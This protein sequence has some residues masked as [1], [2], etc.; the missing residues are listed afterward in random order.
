LRKARVRP[1]QDVSV[2]LPKDSLIVVIGVSGSGKSLLVTDTICAAGQHNHLIS[3][4]LSMRQCL[5]P[6]SRPSC[7]TISGISCVIAVNPIRQTFTPKSTVGTV[8]EIYDYFRILFAGIGGVDSLAEKSNLPELG[9]QIYKRFF[10]KRI[11]VLAPIHQAAFSTTETLEALKQKGFQRV[12]KGGE[13]CTLE[14][15]AKKPKRQETELSMVVD[16]IPIQE[17]CLERLRDSIETGVHLSKGE[18]DIYDCDTT[19]VTKFTAHLSSGTQP[20][21]MQ[22]SPLLFSFN[23][24]Q[25]ACPHCEGLGECRFFS[26]TLVVPNPEKSL[27]EGAIKPWER[28][29]KEGIRRLFSPLMDRYNI[30]LTTAFNN[31]PSRLQNIIL[32][33]E[34]KRFAGVIPLLEQRWDKT[35]N[36]WVKEELQKYRQEKPCPTCCGTRLRSEALLFKISGKTIADINASSI[37]GIDRFVRALSLREELQEIARPL[38]EEISKRTRFLKDVGLGQITLNR[39]IHTLSGGEVQRAR[40][41]ARFGTGAQNSIYVL[42]EPSVGLHP[43]DNDRLIKALCGLR[44]LGNTVIVAEHDED[45]IRAADYIV[46]LGPQAGA[47]GGQVLYAGSQDKFFQHPKSITAAYLRAQENITIPRRKVS[48]RDKCLRLKGITQRNLCE[49][50]LSFP[51][52]RMIG[53]SGVSGSGKSSLI[54]GTLIPRVKKAIAR[55][56]TESIEGGEHLSRVIAVDQ[57]SFGRAARSHIIGYMGS[58]SLVRELFASLPASKVQGY[59]AQRFSLNLRGGRCEA[60]QGEGKRS[61]DMQYLS[62]ASV[63]C[64]ACKGRRYNAETLRVQLREK[65]IADVLDLSISEALS[66]FRGFSAIAGKLQVLQEL[67]LGYLTIGQPTATLSEGELQRLKIAKELARRPDGKTLYVFDEP[68]IGLHF[69]DIRRLLRVLE[70]LVHEG[71]TVLIIEHNLEVLKNMDWII[72]LGVQ[73]AEEEQIIVQGPPEVIVKDPRSCT[74]RYLAKKLNWQTPPTKALRTSRRSQV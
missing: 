3:L 56:E 13:F 66:F 30:V 61:I 44:D 38:L 33:G 36:Q 59:T 25:G 41:A 20:S 9:L 53:V 15:I 22:V 24:A 4:P 69:E 23:S 26:E 12:Y 47:A 8:T 65:S 6:V 54:F 74:G 50:T 18:I 64:E 19:R 58:F 45:I 52:E 67:G 51:L 43:H 68:T 40:L 21:N 70:K 11:Y 72:D 31:L 2:D 16:R 32:H 29:G 73:E 28:L 46:D 10:S 57:A 63:P 49:N 60:C 14:E 39:S 1:L 5:E 35:D 62:K 17:G 27:L 48:D 34:P 7:D 42:D 71:N 55:K 37:E